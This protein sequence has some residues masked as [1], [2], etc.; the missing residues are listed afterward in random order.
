MRSTLF[1]TVIAGAIAAGA[2]LLPATAAQAAAKHCP[3]DGPGFGGDSFFGD[4]FGFHDDGIGFDDD[5]MG[6]WDDGIGF[7]WHHRVDHDRTIIV[8]VPAKTHHHHMPATSPTGNAAGS[9]YHKP[10]ANGN[11]NSNGGYRKSAANA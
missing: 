4:R 5:G 3:C 7:P 6:L 1:K 9:G 10:S 8:V 2:L 11:A